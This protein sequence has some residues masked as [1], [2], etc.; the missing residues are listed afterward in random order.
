MEASVDLAGAEKSWTMILNHQPDIASPTPLMQMFFD[1]SDSITN[2]QVTFLG[3]DLL[4]LDIP[5]DTVSDD[6][7]SYDLYYVAVLN[8]GRQEEYSDT[9]DY[10]LE[11]PFDGYTLSAFELSQVADYYPEY[12]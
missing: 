7:D 9:E 10:G 5:S 1:D 8:A 11:Q 4:E 2:C 3:P 12:M 6:I